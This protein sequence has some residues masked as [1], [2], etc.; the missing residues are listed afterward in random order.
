VFSCVVFIYPSANIFV[1]LFSLP[2]LA[3][4]KNMYLVSA[5]FRLYIFFIFSSHVELSIFSCLFNKIHIVGYQHPQIGYVR[6]GGS[7]LGGD[8]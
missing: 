6:I 2:L 3:P 7:F 1:F 8:M 4:K 5:A